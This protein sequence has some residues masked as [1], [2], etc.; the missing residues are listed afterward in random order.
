MSIIVTQGPLPNDGDTA[1]PATFLESWISGTTI[2]NL[3]VDAFKGGNV[4]WVYSQTDAP[5]LADR[6]VGMLWF[7][8]GDGR[9]YI[10]DNAESPSQLTFSDANW[11]PVSERRELW[12][13]TMNPVQKGQAMTMY[14]PGT[15]ATA[16]PC[17]MTI[18]D[19]SGV[20][21][22]EFWQRPLWR[23]D[24]VWTSS[25][26]VE[27]VVVAKESAASGALTRAVELGVVDMLCESGSTLAAGPM[28]L[29]EG[30]AATGNYFYRDD[31]TQG[32]Q[33]GRMVI[34]EALTSG[35]TGY[36][37]NAPF[38]RPG[39]LHIMPLLGVCSDV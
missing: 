2:A 15:Q 33:S 14:D 16:Y 5:A 20:N 18:E 29:M 10:W 31:P 37:L 23:V 27:F 12:V 17:I 24:P 11:M 35:P 22:A 4:Q 21:T 28:H 9:L 36:T 30:V 39:F 25:S 13:Q 32:S 3:G 26:L 6:F 7:K 1:D 34:A 19:Q 38:L 8:R